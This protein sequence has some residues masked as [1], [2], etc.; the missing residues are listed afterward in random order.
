MEREASARLVAGAL[1]VGAS[2]LSGNAAL[3]SAAGG[4][5]VN[6]ASEPLGELW[7]LA[8]PPAG[9]G[10]ALARAYER[11]LRRAVAALRRQYQA[12]YGRAADVAAFALLGAAAD[13]LARAEYPPGADSPV[14]AQRALVGALD[15]LLHGHEPR[16]AAWIKARLLECTALEFQHELAA[17]AEAWRAFHDWLTRQTA[18]AAAALGHSLADV[19]RVLDALRQQAGALDAATDRLEQLL[20]GLR[21]ELRR[22]AAGVAVPAAAGSRNQT[23]G[24]SARVGIAVA[25]DVHGN[26]TQQSGGVNFGS[27]NTIGK[28]GDTVQGDKHVHYYGP[29]GVA[30][31]PAGSSSDLL[32]AHRARLQVLEHKRAMFGYNTPAEI[33]TEIETIRDEIARLGGEAE[34]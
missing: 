32:K 21:D 11:A 8:L 6:W 24:G 20:D 1:L 34:P 4:V 17:D 27:G 18:Q 23:I 15:G 16:Q 12:E 22:I 14:A 5:G 7:R 2:L 28:A 13:T 3:I 9:P 30:G 25:G 19:P 33:I 10:G 29:P 26:V 31:A